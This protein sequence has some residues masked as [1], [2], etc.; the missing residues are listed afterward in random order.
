MESE[1]VK[2]DDFERVA[3]AIRELQ[4]HPIMRTCDLCELE[5]DANKVIH[6]HSIED[7]EQE[8][9]LDSLP[10]LREAALGDG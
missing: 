2:W 7:W 1:T 5:Y 8:F 10:G 4:S 9:G 3:R 6:G